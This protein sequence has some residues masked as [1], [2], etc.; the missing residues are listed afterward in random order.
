MKREEK[1]KELL[2]Y[3]EK[4]YVQYIQSINDVE[5]IE[6]AKDFKN[7]I[8]HNMWNSWFLE[9]MYTVMVYIRKNLGG[10]NFFKMIDFWVKHRDFEV[11]EEFILQIFDEAKL[12]VK[13]K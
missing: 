12:F 1:E 6:D 13:E 7:W 11:F 9:N 5:A 3:I 8:G 2:E 4:Q 10:R